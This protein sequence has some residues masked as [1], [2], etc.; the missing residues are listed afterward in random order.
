[1]GKCGQVEKQQQQRAFWPAPAPS[2][3]SVATG[4]QGLKEKIQGHCPLGLRGV[5]GR[6]MFSER[7]QMTSFGSPMVWQL[8]G[9]TLEPQIPWKVR[10]RKVWCK[11]DIK[12]PLL[13]QRNELG[14]GISFSNP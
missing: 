5:A 7:D 14:Q 3:D 11:A 1:M 9:E 8:P 2:V 10:M 4:D 12:C 6:C 13:E